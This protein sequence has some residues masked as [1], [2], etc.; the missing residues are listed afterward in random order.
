MSSIEVRCPHCGGYPKM[1]ENT[2][3]ENICLTL[4]ARRC[5]ET[6]NVTVYA[7]GRATI[8]QQ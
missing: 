2:Y 7:A 1:I 5:L 6:V 3:G 4:W 8:A